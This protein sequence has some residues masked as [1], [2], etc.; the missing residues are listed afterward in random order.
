MKKTAFI[1]LFI[2]LSACLWGQ[3]ARK[4]IRQGNRHYAGEKYADSETA[5]RKALVNEPQNPKATFNLGDALYRQEK[6]DEATGQFESIAQ[7]ETNNIN[8]SKAFHN[9][10]NA[11]LQAGKIDESISSYKEAL[12]RN[13]ADL[14]T[15]YNLAFAQNLKKQQQ[16]QQKQQP[17]DQNGEDKEGDQK[18]K[19]DQDQKDQQNQQQEQKDKQ[20]EQKD[21]QTDQQKSPPVKM[22]KEDAKRLLEALANDEK[23]VQEKVKKAKAAA[24]RTRSIKDW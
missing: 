16:Q 24:V 22:S 1:L 4:E 7:R 14:D 15:K 6:F 20:G 17:Q 2:S 11:Q 10:G 8:S 9:L 23:K 21:Q 12:R 5:Y 18:D 13:P 19:Q 3:P